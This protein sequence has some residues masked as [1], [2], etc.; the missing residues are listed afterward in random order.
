MLNA[1]LTWADVH[2][3]DGSSEWW[4]MLETAARSARQANDD[5]GCKHASSCYDCTY[6]IPN[7]VMGYESFMGVDT[8][9]AGDADE[10]RSR[11]PESGDLYGR[12]E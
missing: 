3:P 12:Y 9:R 10:P 11:C 8:W 7:D 5:T 2:P 6:R 4:A 1:V